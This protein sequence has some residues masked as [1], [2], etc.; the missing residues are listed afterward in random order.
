M[1]VWLTALLL[2]CALVLP[3]AFAEE[4]APPAYTSVRA[5]PDGIGKVYL[6]REIAQ[7]MTFH[8]APWLE[9]AERMEEERPDRV[10]ATLDL[11]PGMTVA[12]VGAGSGYYS[13]RIAERV[14]AGGTVYAVDIQPEMVRL[15]QQQMTQR[16]AANVKAILGTST[17]PRLPAATLDLA[18]MVDV[19]HELE[20]P[21]EM[22]ASITRALKPGG[23]LVFVEFKGNDPTVPIKPL[24]TLTEAQVRKEA[25]VQP[26]EWEK[27][28][29]NLPWQHVIV[30]R[31]R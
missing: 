19:Y 17:D 23:R 9:R 18:L 31:K 5:S 8:G 27:T 22:L 21:Y 30:F 12:D 16:G 15:L 4:A 13:W 2:L 6:G 14:G 25:A 26:L 10:L 7:V 1:R 24:H 29:S 20:Y 3:G 28:V 11:K